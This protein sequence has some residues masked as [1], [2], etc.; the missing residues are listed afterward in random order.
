MAKIDEY[1]E[2]LVSEMET[3]RSDID[4]LEKLNLKLGQTKV[5]MDSTEFKNLT[6]RQ[7]QQLESFERQLSSYYHKYDDRLKNA[8][9]YPKWAVITFVASL[10]L[11][12]SGILYTFHL[13]SNIEKEHKA[14]Y[15][16]GVTDYDNYI[17]QFFESNPKAYE[18]FEKWK[19]E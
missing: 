19:A 1:M 8:G 13:K 5:E 9:V 17:K 11:C 3:F 18:S 16:Q 4:R 7:H 12:F 15:D 2:L 6:N 10:I 14:S